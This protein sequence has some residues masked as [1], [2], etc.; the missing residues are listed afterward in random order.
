MTRFI[1][2]I[3]SPIAVVVFIVAFGAAALIDD[4][5]ALRRRQ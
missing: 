5:A 4:V 1:M 3:L 2:T